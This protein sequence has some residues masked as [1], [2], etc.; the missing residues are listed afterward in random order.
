MI[1]IMVRMNFKD[2]QPSGF[3]I[4]AK[5]AEYGNFTAAAKDLGISQAAVSQAIDKLE[6]KLGFK[7]FDRGRRE[8]VLT[9]R[10]NLALPCAKRFIE[11]TRFLQASLTGI[12][13]KKPKTLRLGFSEVADSFLAED[14]EKVLIPLLDRIEVKSGMIPK[15][16][17]DFDS[18]LLDI[19]VAPDLPS[20]EGT[21]RR[22]LVEE[23][24]FVVCPKR[25]ERCLEKFFVR[26]VFGE[27]GLPF[28]SY[29]PD[30]SDRRK[31]QKLLRQLGLDATV[32]I[33]LENTR[34]LVA[35]VQ[36]GLG[37]TVLPPLNLLCGGKISG[38]SV[39]KIEGFGLSKKLCIVAKGLGYTEYLDIIEK[40]F[41]DCFESVHIPR[42]LSHLPALGSGIS[43]TGKEPG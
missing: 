34:G 12:A 42:L 3:L 24:Y 22:V 33:E 41:Y 36:N 1:V 28:I 25:Y 17:E 40:T 39:R 38:L 18:G 27:A 9:H 16:T 10:G 26:D 43:L 30:S 21:E 19:V 13:E 20:R 31:G 5:S 2:I 14:V 7:L 35:A 8:I 32:K 29:R 6:G 37:W 23:S 4:F 15:I 11:E